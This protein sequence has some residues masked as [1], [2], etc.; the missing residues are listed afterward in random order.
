MADSLYLCRHGETEWTL[1]G[2]HT[3]ITD[4]PLTENGKRQAEQLRSRLQNCHFDAV[5]VSPLRRA[6]MTCNIAGFANVAEVNE[7]LIEWKYGDYEGITTQEIRHS[8]PSWTI[9]T[10]GAP[11]GES[12][13]DIEER[14]DRVIEMV[15]MIEGDVALFSSGHFSR[16]L[17]VRWLGWPIKFGRQF[18]LSTATISILAYERSVPAVKAWNS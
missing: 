12:V 5:F 14:C 9:F 11:N 18:I 7:D 6:R 15:N 1:S 3:S 17:A 2:Q 13:A 8:V 4:L 16:A 10:H